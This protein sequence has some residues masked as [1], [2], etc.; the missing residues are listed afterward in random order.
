MVGAL[1]VR[2][3]NGSGVSW[4]PQ[5]LI[6]A[7]IQTGVLCQAGTDQWDIGLTINLMRLNR[8]ENSQ[9]DHIWQ[10]VKTTALAKQYPLK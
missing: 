3:W 6:A 4:L 9:L 2:A 7:D 1:R 5:S 10:H 8:K